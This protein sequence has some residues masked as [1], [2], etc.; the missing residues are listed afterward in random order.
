MSGKALDNLRLVKA[1][2][3]AAIVCAGVGIPAAAPSRGMSPVLRFNSSQLTP[4]RI[5]ATT[6]QLAAR[7]HFYERL[8]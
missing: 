1:F 2:T 7:C 8:Y 4:P 6:T 3:I 5:H